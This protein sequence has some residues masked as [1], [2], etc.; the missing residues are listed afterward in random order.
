[1]AGID[2]VCYRPEAELEANEVGGQPWKMSRA[3]LDEIA[4]RER[5]QRGVR[6]FAGHWV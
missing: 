1:V 6:K 5:D 2:V 3:E 4:G